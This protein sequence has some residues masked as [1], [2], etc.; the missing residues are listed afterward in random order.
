LA[1]AAGL[2]LTGCGKKTIVDTTG[3]EKSY[4]TA[5]SP[6]QNSAKKALNSIKTGHVVVALTE[7]KSLAENPESTAEQKA[8]IYHV[9][10][11][12]EAFLG[13]K[14]PRETRVALDEAKQASRTRA[15]HF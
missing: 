13:S 4:S 10:T 7:L 6:A 8:E 3:I 2:T 1:L 5:G 12:L 15:A 9:V 11:Q 14:V